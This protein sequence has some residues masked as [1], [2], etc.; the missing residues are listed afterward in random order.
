MKDISKQFEEEQK[1]QAEKQ[2]RIKEAKAKKAKAKEEPTWDEVWVTGYGKKKGIFQTKI[3]DLDK[4]RLLEVKQAIEDGELGTHVES[5]KKFSKSHALNLYKILM[6]SRKEKIIAK[7][8]A[9]K[10][11]NYKLITNIFD[12][13]KLAQDLKKEEETGLDTETNGLD[14]DKNHIVG[15][16]ITL[17]KADYHVYIPIRHEQEWSEIQLP[18]KMV[19]SALKEYLEDSSIGKVLHNAK[20]DFHMFYREG[21]YVK[22]LLMDTLIAMKV[23]NENEP[24]YALKNLATKYGKYFGFEDKSSTYE[25]LFGKGGF[26]NTPFDIGTVYACKDTHLCYKFYKWIKTQFERLPKLGKIYFEIELPN[27][28]TAFDMEKNGMLVDL[29]FAQKYTVKLSA[30]VREMEAKLHEIF[31]GININSNDQ[32]GKALY[33]DWGLEDVSKKRSVDADTIKFLAQ[34]NE[35]LQLLLDY[36]GKNKLLTTYFEALPQKVWQRDSR[37]HGSFNQ[38][39]TKTGRYSSNN[40]NL[41]NIPPEARPMVVAPKG[42]V[43]LGKDLSQIEPRCLAYMSGDKQFQEPYLT[44]KDLYVSLARKVFNLEEKYCLDGAYDPTHTF[45]PRK[46]MKTGLLAVMYGTST[47]TLSQQLEIPIEEAEQF[48]IDFLETYPTAKAYIQSI[49][50]FVDKNEY[51]ETYLGRKRRFKGHKQ[52][53]T[54]YHAVCKKIKQKLGYIP[55][56]IWAEKKLS[57]S[58]KQE[59]WEVAKAYSR[60]TRQAV[61]AVIQGSSADYIKLVMQRVNA[62]LKNLGEEYKLIGTIH[63]EILLEV[64]DTVAPEVIAELDRIMTNIEWFKFPVKTDTVVMY[65]WGEEI[66]VAQWMEN[67]EE[68]NKNRGGAYK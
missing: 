18:P 11:D 57:R 37:L 29:S 31:G 51:V 28:I 38:T 48:I 35:N 63:D 15:I 7:M 26:E 33:D 30:E 42:K 41:Q 60:V 43:I 20:F 13:K 68:Y 16:S 53:A 44:K 22:G 24:T 1:K 34:S 25:E 66:P 6:E 50:D 4:Q 40:P 61:N 54:K 14:Y 59:Y 65:K 67:R 12:L 62:Y 23:L 45:K 17:P 19:F 27:T 10:P 21:I 56:N 9:E 36:R 58:L 32:L 2:Q 47:Y 5:M 3:S 64:P 46:R 49:K 52:V 8:I 55:S 39:G